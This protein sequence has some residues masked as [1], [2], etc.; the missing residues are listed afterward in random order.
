MPRTLSIALLCLIS[1]AFISPVL[2]AQDDLRSEMRA[3]REEH[4]REMSAM[5]QEYE[6]RISSLESELGRVQTDAD[7]KALE[8]A[9]DQATQDFERRGISNLNQ[10]TLFDNRFNPAISLIGDLVFAVSDK[11]DTFETLDR[12]IMRSVELGI[13]GKVDADTE[14]YGV[15]H[16]DEDEVELEEAFILHRGLLSET[17][18]LKAGRFNRD[19]GRLSIVHDHDLP[20]VDKPAVIQDYLGGSLRGTGI[21]LHHWTPM[22]ETSLIRFSFGIGNELDGDAHPVIGPLAGE[23][24]AH[25]DD[26]FEVFGERQLDNFAFNAR[27]TAQF[28]VGSN[29]IFQIGTSVAWAPNAR[30]IIEEEEDHKHGGR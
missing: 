25:D 16:V 26:D 5:R 22:G 20:F 7:T 13:Y 24:H 3:M 1:T 4:R 28:E 11:D 6:T 10:V 29:G 9:V 18:W 2:C 12:F 8:Q 30:T 14:Y 27:V 17:S 15:I 23:P 21:E 19:F